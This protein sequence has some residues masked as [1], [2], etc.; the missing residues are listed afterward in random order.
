LT[1]FCPR[2][3]NVL[4]IKIRN[5][6]IYASTKS[7]NV[8]NAKRLAR[9]SRTTILVTQKYCLIFIVISVAGI[10]GFVQ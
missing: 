1:T 9:A 2:G 5:D 4:A 7:V 10:R 6:A 3:W 8:P